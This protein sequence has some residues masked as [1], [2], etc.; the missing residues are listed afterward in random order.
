MGP[1]RSP[2]VV[3]CFTCCDRGDYK[4]TIFFALVRVVGCF[5]SCLSECYA[6]AAYSGSLVPY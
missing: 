4:A 2:R 1:R 5:Y 6:D 3:C